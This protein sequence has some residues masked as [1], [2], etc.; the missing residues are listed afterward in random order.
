MEGSMNM[1]DERKWMGLEEMIALSATRD[2]AIPEEQLVVVKEEV[3]QEHPVVA[4]PP[5]LVGQRWTW[6]CTTTEMAHG[7]GTE[8]WCPTPPRSPE[9]ESSPRRETLAC[10]GASSSEL[11]EEPSVRL[12]SSELVWLESLQSRWSSSFAWRAT[13]ALVVAS[14]FSSRSDISIASWST[15]TVFGRRRRGSFSA[16]VREW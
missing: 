16:M 7:V 8:P 5:E 15:L 11:E 3:N 2:V 13:F 1:Y 4:F 9:R 12:E 10:D 14:L 6:S